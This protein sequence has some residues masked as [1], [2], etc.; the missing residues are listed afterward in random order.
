MIEA[1]EMNLRLALP[2]SLIAVVSAA[3]PAWAAP[4]VAPTRLELVVEGKKTAPVQK[5]LSAALTQGTG[6]SVVPAGIPADLRVHVAVTDGKSRTVT[7]DVISP[8]GAPAGHLEWSFKAKNGKPVPADQ[9]AALRALIAQAIA[10]P[11]AVPSK[12]EPKPD[13]KPEP[14]PDLKPD[15]KP[16]PKPDAKPEPKPKPKLADEESPVLLRVALGAGGRGRGFAYTGATKGALA[17]YAL[18]LGPEVSGGLE[19]FPGGLAV[20]DG[21]ATDVGVFFGGGRQL[22]LSTLTPD[23]QTLTTRAY[24]YELGVVGRYPLGMVEPGLRLGYGVQAFHVDGGDRIHLASTEESAL[25]LQAAVR[26]RVLD[27]LAVTADVGGGLLMGTGQLGTQ[28]YFPGAGGGQVGGG[29]DAELGLPLDLFVQAG[30]EYQRDLISLKPAGTPYQATGATDQYWGVHAR[31]GW[32][33]K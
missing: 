9:A 27:R 28:A 32:A 13:L 24:R 4:A 3:A 16:E 15:A 29:L 33:W 17:G 2:S 1:Q 19:L 18:G 12:P 26:V 7:V 30:G 31:L 6:W 8:A 11:A 21:L 25:F 10:P 23:N 5:A 14:K 20:P 22:G